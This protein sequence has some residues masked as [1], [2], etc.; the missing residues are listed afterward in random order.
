[1]EISEASRIIELLTNGINPDTGSPLPKRSPYN[2]P[3]VMR[4]LFLAQ[5]LM[6]Q[7]PRPL[8]TTELAGE[9]ESKADNDTTPKVFAR[10]GEKWTPIEDEQLKVEFEEGK[11]V[12]WIAKEHAR[13]WTAIAYRLVSL[14][15]V[16]SIDV[17]K[18]PNNV[19]VT[20]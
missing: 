15:L 16:E 8:E 12:G 1:M 4:A 11:S 5:G 10:Q 18:Q 13:S 2:S 19:P 7:S 20:E 6:Q 3:R 9:S 17:L 14:G